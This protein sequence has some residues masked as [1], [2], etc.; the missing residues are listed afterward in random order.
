ME[1]HSL[2]VSWDM[3]RTIKVIMSSLSKVDLNRAPELTEEAIE[4]LSIVDKKLR[5]VEEYFDRPLDSPD[6]YR[7]LVEIAKAR[8]DNEMESHY[9]DRIRLFE[10]NEWEFKGRQQNFFG[11]NTEALRCYEK[12][13][14]LVPDLELALT[15]KEKAAK[16]VEKALKSLTKMEA[17]VQ[18]DPDNADSWYKLGILYLDLARI[19][20]ALDSYDKALSIDPN[21]VDALCRKGTALEGVGRYKEAVHYFEEA[22]SIKPTALIAKRGMNYAEFALDK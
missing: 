17:K 19:Q 2:D 12:A 13:L 9:M 22:L 14:E 16:R 8:N 11:N 20:D 5:E 3:D 4:I 18:D 1:I 21:H 7:K 15:G 10:A 6:V